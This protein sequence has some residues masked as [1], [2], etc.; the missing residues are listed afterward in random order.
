WET[1]RSVFDY[2]VKEGNVAQ[3]LTIAEYPF[4]RLPGSSG[5]TQLLA[6][7]IELASPDSHTAGRLL[8]RY[9][10]AL[11][12]ELGDYEDIVDNLDQ[13][14]TIARRENDATLE[15][16]ILTTLAN[17]Q[18]WHLRYS[19][20]LE[21]SLRA[22]ELDR[23]LEYV[24][25]GEANANWYAARALIPLGRTE[26]A[27]ANAGLYLALAEERRDRFHLARALDAHGVLAQLE[28]N[29]QVAREY[30]DQGLEIDARDARL[31]YHRAIL[32]YQ[33]GNISQ[34]DTY[35]EC[36]LETMLISPAN[37]TPHQLAPMTIGLA[38]H[39]TG[40]SS[41]LDLAERTARDM[42]SLPS[43]L[44]FY[45]Q[46]ARNG[47]ALIALVRKDVREARD[48]YDALARWPVTMTTHNLA[49]GHRVLGLLAM[50]VDREDL[51]AQHLDESVNFCREAGFR[52]EL[53]WS[54]HDYAEAL[55]Q[56]GDASNRPEIL[57]LLQDSLAISSDLGMT[58]LEERV[59][60]LQ[61][62]A[63]SY[64]DKSPQYPDGLSQR[65]VEVLRLVASGMTDREIAD[66]LYISARTV[67]YHV[68]NILD[69][70][71]CSNRAEA[72]TYA[73]RNGL[74]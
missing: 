25:S 24:T 16:N 13:A 4:T 55:L 21:N 11:S 39:I 33:Q 69:K 70:T 58:P 23:R 67:G 2:H 34:G 29:W 72:S 42:L 63:E 56:R 28:G 47:L 65:E 61:E 59:A 62:R 44:P 12:S 10:S 27:R 60:A 9:A 51:A 20:S 57:S 3:A 32:E 54:C 26:A 1:I 73:N 38:A 48:Q 15:L 5:T 31:L 64:A 35:T 30:S 41:R 50:T 7:S 37:S 74:V 68:G 53:A 66:E 36:L 8:A 52:P 43:I 14:L 6:E 46:L 49:C 40:D 45:A 17:T 22:M 71:N 18:F 19:E